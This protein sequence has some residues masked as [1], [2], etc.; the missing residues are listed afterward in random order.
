M[1][2]RTLVIG[3]G[4]AGLAVA[5]CLKDEG[6]VFDIAD[7][8][9]V[10]GG[11]YRRMYDGVTL[12][13]PTRYTG[14]PGRP[15][16]CSNEYVTVPEYRAY[17][18][19]YA[20]QH[21]VKPQ[22]LEV[23]GLDRDGDGFRVQFDRPAKNEGLYEAVVVAS[24]IF[25][26]PLRPSI[27]GLAGAGPA[28]SGRPMVIHA[29]DW[30]GP[31]SIRGRRLLLI[32]GATSGIEIAEECAGAGLPVILSARRGRVKI[33]PQR[34]MGRDIHD[35]ASLIERLP[36]GIFGSYCSHWPTHPGLDRGFKAFHR[37]G[38]ISVRG[39]IRRFQGMRVE[40]V[41][42]SEEEVDVVVLA[43]GYRYAPRFLPRQIANAT[44]GRSI[45]RGGESR[46]WPGLFFV[47]THCGGGID[48]QFLRGMARDAAVV[49]RKIRKRLACRSQSP[50]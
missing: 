42:G 43:T 35:Y 5:A 9:G 49:A 17:L 22:R 37:E 19:R 25:D 14:L 21:G 27:T 29:R 20:G 12:A 31:G 44:A 26:H 11:A 32:G 10:P 33:M 8:N 4:P 6:V 47:G 40:F 24:G 3:A 38:L 15:P 2:P 45:T 16:D 36:R 1:L 41:D 34:I 50:S 39:E 13:S 30:A 46:V 48:S 18:D 28:G 23:V 7:R